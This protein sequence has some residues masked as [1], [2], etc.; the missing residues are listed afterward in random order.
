MR[1]GNLIKGM[2]TAVNLGVTFESKLSGK[3][4]I[5]KIKEK[6]IKSIAVLTSITGSS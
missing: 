4:Q 6:A 2:S 3:N 5:S 1:G